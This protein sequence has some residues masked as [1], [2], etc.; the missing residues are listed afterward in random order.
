MLRTTTPWQ[1]TRARLTL[2][3]HRIAAVLQLVGRLE[4]VPGALLREAAFPDLP[5]STAAL[6]LQRLHAERLLWSAPVPASRVTVAQVGR[7]G[8]MPPRPPHLYGI[9]EEGRQWLAEHGADGPTAMARFSV[10]DWKE[11]NVRAA[12]LAHDLMVTTWCASAL[13]GAAR[14]PWLT[15]ARC[16]VEYVSLVDERGQAVQRFDALVV[17]TFAP[18]RQHR[19]RQAWEIPWAE[20]WE[21]EGPNE[22]T[23]RIAVEADRGTEKLVILLGK[24][25][26]YRNLTL[27]GHY[28]ATLGGPVTPVIV[29]T[30]GRRAAQIGR[31]WIHAWPDGRGLVSTTR[32]AEDPVLGALWGCYYTMTERPARE[33]TLLGELGID[34]ASWEASLVR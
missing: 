8:A 16:E 9:T 15:R 18:G 7:G 28:D 10:R 34:R 27:L 13:L 20:G 23:I 29:C 19:G 25:V 24:A 33:V 2:P 3:K 31:E 4:F 12:Q 32:A 6:H 11:P 5:R 17:L 22:R 1:R 14:S 30:A 26:A 21:R